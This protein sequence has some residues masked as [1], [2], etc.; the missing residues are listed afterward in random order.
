MRLCVLAQRWVEREGRQQVEVLAFR[1]ESQLSWDLVTGYYDPSA[2]ESIGTIASWWS[3]GHTSMMP[4]GL[5]CL[6]ESHLFSW[7][8]E[9][10]PQLTAAMEHFNSLHEQAVAAIK[11]YCNVGV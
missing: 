8:V 5:Q 6:V 11:E 2:G 3:R 1:P 9:Q 4:H 7:A 10:S